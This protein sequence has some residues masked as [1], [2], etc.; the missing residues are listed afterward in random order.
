MSTSKLQ[1]TDRR[2]RRLAN[3]KRRIQF[4]LRNRVWSPQDRPMFTARN[5]HYELAERSRGLGP[6][7]IGAMH[8]L[9]RRVGLIDAIDRRLHLL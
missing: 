4:R 2:N 5:I 8:Q 7:G 6:G 3:R 9:G 1:T